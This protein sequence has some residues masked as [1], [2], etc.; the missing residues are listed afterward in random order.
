MSGKILDPNDINLKNSKQK[1]ERINVISNPNEV[2]MR[3]MKENKNKRRKVRLAASLAIVAAGAI[4]ITP[5]IVYNKKNEY[6]EITIESQTESFQTQVLKLKRGSTISNLKDLLDVMPGY[7]L[8]GI[9]KDYE[10]TIPYSE[11]D[12]IEKNVNVFLKFAQKKYS[13]TFPQDQTGYEIIY[14]DSNDDLT[15]FLWGDDFTFSIKLDSAYINSN[16]VVKVNGQICT[17]DQFGYYSIPE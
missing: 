17:P 6:Y 13:I 4:T 7:C 2:L 1:I 11:D 12:K 9:Y 16:I 15:D 10:C 14:F 5:I 3:A 8:V